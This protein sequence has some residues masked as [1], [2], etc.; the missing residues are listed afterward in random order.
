[1]STRAHVEP[2]AVIRPMNFPA[3]VALVVA[4][5]ALVVSVVSLRASNA[6]SGR[7][8]AIVR[9][10]PYAGLDQEAL[11]DAGFTGQLGAAT[12]G[13]QDRAGRVGFTGRLGGS[14]PSNAGSLWSSLDRE[15]LIEAGFTGRLGG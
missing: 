1:M 14:T 8:Q 13:W 10:N 11:K 9:T 7:Q 4:V 6:E 15:A 2:I 3:W 5:A 12:E